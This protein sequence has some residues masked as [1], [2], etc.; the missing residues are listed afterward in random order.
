M[1]KQR[2]KNRGAVRKAEGAPNSAR[3]LEGFAICFVS[4]I[5]SF[6]IYH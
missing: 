1:A 3:E 4:S 2:Q 5:K 6:S